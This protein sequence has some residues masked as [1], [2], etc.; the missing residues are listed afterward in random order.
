MIETLNVKGFGVLSRF[1]PFLICLLQY[2]KFSNLVTGH[3]SFV[4]F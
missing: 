4:S 2:V 3:V 1:M